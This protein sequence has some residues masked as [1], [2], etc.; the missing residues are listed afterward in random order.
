MKNWGIESIE[1]EPEAA[2]AIK[3]FA[4]VNPT[5]KKQIE[6]R[7]NDLLNFPELVWQSAFVKGG[8]EGYFLTKNQQIELAG[9]VY[10]DRRLV[11]ITHFSFHRRGNALKVLQL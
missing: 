3:A 9:K 10:K 8:K 7:V 1:F 11:L 5:Y 4:E 2:K 6:D